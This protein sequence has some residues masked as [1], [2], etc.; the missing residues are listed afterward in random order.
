MAKAIQGL[1]EAARAGGFDHG[2]YVPSGIIRWRMGNIHVGTSAL[3]IA[4]EFWHDR[5]KAY[6]RPLKRA[7]VRAALRE[8]AA[9]RALYRAVMRGL[10]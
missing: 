10:L 1:T 3:T 2:G 7:I 6:A 9:N 4:R 5:A 8:H